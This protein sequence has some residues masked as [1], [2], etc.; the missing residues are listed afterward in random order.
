V[1]RTVS[2]K[3][4]LHTSTHFL[5]RIPASNAANAGVLVASIRDADSM[6]TLATKGCDT[7]TFSPVVARLLFE[8]PLTDAAAVVFEQAAAAGSKP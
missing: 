3:P 7:F 2:F 1:P 4:P 6:A 8:E 5:T